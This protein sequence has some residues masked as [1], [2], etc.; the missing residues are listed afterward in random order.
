MRHSNFHQF[1]PILMVKR[2]NSTPSQISLHD[3]ACLRSIR[4]IP[5]NNNQSPGCNNPR[6]TNRLDYIDSIPMRLLI[7]TE[8]KIDHEVGLKHMS[9]IYGI[10]TSN[11]SVPESW[12]LIQDDKHQWRSYQKTYR[13]IFHC[14]V[15][16]RFCYPFLGI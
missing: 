15:D 16:R 11:Q 3:A 9:N 14:H 12:S 6:I 2:L 13:W 1:L 8:K 4:V 10:C 5:H 7:K